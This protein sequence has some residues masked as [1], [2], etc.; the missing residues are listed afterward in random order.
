MRRSKS[1]EVPLSFERIL[2]KLIFLIAVLLVIAQTLVVNNPLRTTASMIGENSA[3]P[4]NSS[5]IHWKESHITL[6]LE[7][8]STLPHLKVLLNGD[9]INEFDNRYITI[10]VRESDVIEIDGSFYRHEVLVKVLNTTSDVIK[11]VVDKQIT[12][13]GSTVEV[14]T[15]NL[16][17]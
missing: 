16:K 2:F 17:K 5:S 6:Y 9:Q 3:V 4:A 8:Y 11:P 10:P 14:C 1:R 13:N 12:I 15:I 7:N